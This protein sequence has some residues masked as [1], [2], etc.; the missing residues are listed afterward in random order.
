MSEILLRC[1]R[2]DGK[3]MAAFLPWVVEEAALAATGE[4]LR[5][6]FTRQGDLLMFCPSQ[7]E[8]EQLLTI[9]TIS[10]V[11]VE[12]SRPPHLNRSQGSI[13]APELTHHDTEDLQRG[14]QSQGVT[15]VFRPRN[16]KVLILTFNSN[17]VP[18][19]VFAA[20]LRYPVRVVIPL[21]RRCTRCQRYGHKVGSC[22]APQEVC[23][24]CGGEGHS[25]PWCEA[26]TATCPVCGGPHAASDPLCPIW[27]RERRVQA[28]IAEG[29]APGDARRRAEEEGDE[30]PQAPP[31]PPAQTQRP[32]LSPGSMTDLRR[33][34]PLEPPRPATSGPPP[35][36]RPDPRLAARPQIQG[37][38][39]PTQGPQPNPQPMATGPRAPPTQGTQ[40]T[41]PSVDTGPRALTPTETKQNP[42]TGTN[43]PSDT[44]SSKTGAASPSR[45]PLSEEVGALSGSEGEPPSSGAELEDH[46]DPDPESDSDDSGSS[47]ATGADD[48]DRRPPPA[49][50]LSE[51]RQASP[52]TDTTA[53][54]TEASS[55]SSSPGKPPPKPTRTPRPKDRS[56]PPNSKKKEKG[57]YNLR[58][59]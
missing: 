32:R 34:P 47:Q 31:P 9:Q 16:P 27:R 28:L 4:R 6:K 58:H 42:P 2:R 26:A 8:A 22:R 54:D 12:V 21:P 33:Y 57:R 52:P 53:S 55:E 13:W 23:A 45:P 36:S 41:T 48:A 56:R 1:R 18:E 38:A 14:F 25:E 44:T 30:P 10:G 15:E 46:Q 59:H 7:R 40:P 3:P 20:F 17:R 19:E 5:A 37:P 43:Q 39:P 24:M 35:L 29:W 49:P 51:D 50:P 11:E